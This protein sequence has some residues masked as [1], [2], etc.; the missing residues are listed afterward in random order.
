MVARNRAPSSKYVY[1]DLHLYF[2]GLSLRKASERLSQMY[3]RNHDSIRNWIQNF[4]HQ[5]FG[6]NSICWP[7]RVQIQTYQFENEFMI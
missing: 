2:S 5:N 4:Y 7:S 6:F 3:K 1:Y